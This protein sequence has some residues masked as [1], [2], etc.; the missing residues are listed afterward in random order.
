MIKVDKKGRE[1]IQALC[2]DALKL[3][4]IAAYEFVSEVLREISLKDPEEKQV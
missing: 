4:G 3:H 2:S 1:Q